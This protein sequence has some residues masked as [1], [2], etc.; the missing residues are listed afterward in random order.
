MSDEQELESERVLGGTE[1]PPLSL[2]IAAFDRLI[3][4]AMRDDKTEEVLAEFER[5]LHEFLSE[6]PASL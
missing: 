3:L 4:E 5:C 1:R 2:D 6:M